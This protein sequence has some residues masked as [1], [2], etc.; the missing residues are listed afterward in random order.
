MKKN[1]RDVKGKAVRWI[2]TPLAKGY[3]IVKSVHLFQAHA[4]L[5]AAKAN[6][7][8]IRGSSTSTRLQRIQKQVAIANQILTLNEGLAKI[9][10][11]PV[12]LKRS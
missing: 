5:I 12:N 10:S 9:M 2:N 7:F 4:Y 11:Q 6:I 3:K 8:A 1:Q